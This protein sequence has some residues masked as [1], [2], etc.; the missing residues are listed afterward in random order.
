MTSAVVHGRAI[1]ARPLLTLVC[2][3][4]CSLAAVFAALFVSTS[5]QAAPP[6]TG[7]FTFTDHFV[8]N[9]GDVAS[10]PFPFTVDQVG[11]GNFQV[12]FDAQGNAVRVRI[13]N[14]WT[15]TGSAN[16]KTVIEHAAQN[17]T[18]DLVDGTAT[19]IGGIHDQVPAGGVVIHDVG[20]LRFDAD[21]NVTF[22]K[23]Q[24]QGLDGDVAGVCAALSP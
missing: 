18:D 14:E 22:E 12:I 13:H 10:C 2:V 6:A 1:R 5:A 24:H 20:L 11:R 23:G 9:P 4:L 19:L 3:L 15:G 8:V 7:T 17:E 21:G 16:G